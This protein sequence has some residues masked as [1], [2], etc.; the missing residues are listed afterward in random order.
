[1]KEVRALTG[2]RGIAALTVFL[3]HT[4]ETLAV[5]GLDLPVPI[6]TS[7][8][9]LNGGRQVDVFFVL[10]G[11]I[12][13]LIYSAWFA[14]GVDSGTYL[15]FLRRRVAR[16]FPL[17]AFMLALIVA[18]VIAAPIV[19]AHL[20]NGADRFT[21]STLPATLLMV[22]AWGFV[23]PG[24]G[25]W[26][27]PSWSVSI[28]FMAYLLS[29]L[30]LWATASLRRQRPWL[31]VLAAACAGLAL[32][33]FVAWERAGLEGITRGLCEFIFGCALAGLF[34]SRFAGWL[35]SNAGAVLAFLVLVVSF[36]LIPD[37]GFVIA[38]GVAAILL[39][40]S[41]TNWLSSFFGWT[42]VY[43]LGEISYS[44][45]L[46]HF[47]FCSIA[48]R[49]V[50]VKWMRTSTVATC[51]GLLLIVAFVIL[52]STLTYYG[53]ERPGRDWMSGRRNRP[54][55]RVAA[56]QTTRW[57]A[58]LRAWFRSFQITNTAPIPLTIPIPASERASSRLSETSASAP[59]T[60]IAS[61]HLS[62]RQT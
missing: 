60:A 4:R 31:L 54:N 55:A 11:F 19:H 42:P 2:I 44:I 56:R 30:L 20:E 34:D 35:R 13:A 50:S 53:V 33:H 15:K 6:L 18:F 46:G 41:G 40:L 5:R 24:G 23:D 21:W 47:L 3:D 28:E 16:I 57:T 58:R 8:L 62:P 17:H 14:Q 49:I 59:V 36:A 10:S 22:H 26:N 39:S 48:F 61:A 29:P 45:Y 12:L 38:L 43:F 37:T 52:M 32:N 25:P 7:R 27:P 51:L 1:M 9:L